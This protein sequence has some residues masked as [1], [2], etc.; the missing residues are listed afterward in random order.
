MKNT[1]LD[2]LL[3]DVM[4]GKDRNPV[5]HQ[6]FKL[7]TE[8]PLGVYYWP[9][10]TPELGAH[11]PPEAPAS[12]FGPKAPRFCLFSDGDIGGGQFHR[13]T[14]VQAAECL[15]EMA[16][17]YV[18]WILDC[19]LVYRLDDDNFDALGIMRDAASR[20]L[21]PELQLRFTRS[22]AGWAW[23]IS[24]TGFVNP[25]VYGP[26]IQAIPEAGRPGL[27]DAVEHYGNVLSQYLGGYHAWLDADGAWTMHQPKPAR[28]KVDKKGR[29]KKFYRI[30]SSGFMTFAPATKHDTEKVR[31]AG[32]AG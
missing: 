7:L 25:Y 26:T 14:I 32:I 27:D 28:T 21:L 2:Y 18:S 12:T 15:V 24:P 1:P 6:F 20:R 29:V 10:W 23:R 22:G 30:A 9:D 19:V 17:S 8:F 5:S 4:L 11:L 31:A 13:P 16:P 3:H